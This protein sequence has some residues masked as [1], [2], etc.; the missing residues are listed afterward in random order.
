MRSAQVQRVLVR[1]LL[2]GMILYLLLGVAYALVSL[3]PYN[4][5]S[6]NV[7]GGFRVPPLWPIFDP[8]FWPWM[9]RA[10]WMH[11]VGVFAWLK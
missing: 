1:V 4:V 7:N 9:L 3:V 2:A 10:D 8:F 5:H 11:R 6:W